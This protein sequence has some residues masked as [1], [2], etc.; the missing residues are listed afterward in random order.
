MNSKS[1]AQHS[2]LAISPHE[3]QLVVKCVSFGSLWWE[4]PGDTIAN[5][6]VMNTT[7]FSPREVR[8]WC[9]PTILYGGVVRINSNRPNLIIRYDDLIGECYRSDGVVRNGNENR[10][11]L[12]PRV[13]TT[14][15]I[16]CYLVRISNAR[17]GF[18]NLDSHPFTGQIQLVS[19]SKRYDQ[20]E[21]LLLMWP[22][23]AVTTSL[24]RLELACLLNK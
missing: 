2:G 7:G 17:H 20:Q 9:E 22:G 5:R 14:F 21:L 12:H 6:A 19:A 11:F 13:S 4:R 8:W 18:V 15:P 10:L 24:G 16:D 3:R 23:S 1:H